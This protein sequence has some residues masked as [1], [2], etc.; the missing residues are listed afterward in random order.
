MNARDVVSAIKDSA[1]MGG[2]GFC[3]GHLNGTAPEKVAL[4]FAVATL[5]T[6]L[7]YQLEVYLHTDRN[8]VRNY[9]ASLDANNVSALAIHLIST[10]VLYRMR[11]IDYSWAMG[12]TGLSIAVFLFNG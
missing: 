12:L 11:L 1:I 10:C 7:I 5:A 6:R 2:L 8:G 9:K 3:V 4:I